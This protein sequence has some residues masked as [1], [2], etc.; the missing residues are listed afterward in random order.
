VID[1]LVESAARLCHAVQGRELGD[2]FA[3]PGTLGQFYLSQ[4]SP[5]PAT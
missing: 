2:E 3:A 4:H 5:R 1:T